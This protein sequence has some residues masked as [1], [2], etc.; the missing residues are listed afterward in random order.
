MIWWFSYLS[1]L[2][3]VDLYLISNAVISSYQSCFILFDTIQ[4]FQVFTSGLTLF[5][6][7]FFQLL[8]ER[9]NE[10]IFR[11]I[12]SDDSFDLNLSPSPSPSIPP[13]FLHVSV[14]DIDQ[15]NLIMTLVG[16]PAPELVMKISSESVR[17]L[18]WFFFSHCSCLCFLCVALTRVTVYF[19][20]LGLLPLLV[21]A[22]VFS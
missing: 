20:A 6:P 4:T 5:F 21:I 18:P 19:T 15:L 11:H 14:L 3:S 13:V 8:N 17:V 16:T 1:P 22:P 10:W 12:F 2:G 7:I 9:M